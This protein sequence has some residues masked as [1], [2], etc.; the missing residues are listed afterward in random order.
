MSIKIREIQRGDIESIVNYWLHSDPEYLK[1]MGVDLDKLPKRKSLSEMLNEQIDTPMAEKNSL[2][3]I[4]EFEETTIGHCN[5]V[6]RE[7]GE[8]AYMHLHIWKKED[9]QKGI[10]SEMVAR[11]CQYFFNVFDLKRIISEPYALNPA[12]HKVLLRVGFELEKE[13]IT[14]PGSLSFKQR[15]CRYVLSREKCLSRKN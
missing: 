15:V 7:K 13:Y 6:E 10:G 12:P 3:L 5:I 1:D 8:Q 9:R 11:S 2:A 14:I 4:C